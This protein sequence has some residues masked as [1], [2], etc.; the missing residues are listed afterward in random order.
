MSK[1]HKTSKITSSDPTSHPRHTARWQNLIWLLVGL[2]VVIVAVAAFLLLQSKITAP[3]EISAAQAYEKFQQG[4][5]FLD[6]RSQAEWDQG[7][8]AKSTLIPLDELQNRLNE[9]PK[10]RDIVV[11]CHSGVRS[12]EGM[13]ILQQ[14]GFSRM[15]SMTG[16]LIAWQAAG[17]PLEGSAP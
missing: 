3:T 16:G 17:Y 13:T 15:A 1:K 2:G 10:D 7:H 12:K 9:L 6:V 11:V 5:F 8:I 14:A 4:A